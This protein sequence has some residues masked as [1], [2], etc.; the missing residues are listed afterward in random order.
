MQR[1]AGPIGGLIVDVRAALD[2]SLGEPRW[3]QGEGRF[4]LTYRFTSS[5]EPIVTAKLKVEINTREHFSVLG[6]SERIFEVANPW[7]SGSATIATYEL[8]EL[9]GTKVRAL[10]QRKKG[11]DIFDLYFGLAEATVA[12]DDVV[13]CFLEYMEFGGHSVTRAQYEKDM[14]QKLSD[15]LFLADID[16]MIRPDLSCDLLEGWHVIHDRIVAKLPGA[17]WKGASVDDDLDESAGDGNVGGE[18]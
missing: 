12:D 15:P 18:P 6:Y 7:F 13:R 9:L 2:P 17:P 8:A 14:A 1:N 5:F 3:K 4:T 11:R 16:A 10:Y